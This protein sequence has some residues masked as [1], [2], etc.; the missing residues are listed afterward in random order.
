MGQLAVELLVGKFF[1]RKKSQVSLITYL[2]II[3]N[4]TNPNIFESILNIYI[5]MRL[6]LNTYWEI[7]VLNKFVYHFHED[8]V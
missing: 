5:Y 8:N 1:N 3:I 7:I 2:K 4:L 6:Y